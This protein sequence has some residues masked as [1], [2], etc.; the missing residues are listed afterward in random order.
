M[1]AIAVAG[2]L[3][4]VT[5]AVLFYVLVEPIDRSETFA[6]TAWYSVFQVAVLFGAFLYGVARR[7]QSG[8]TV[9]VVAATEMIVLAYNVV[10]VAVMIVFNVLLPEYRTVARYYVTNFAV[11]AVAAAS[12]ALLQLVPAAHNVGHAEAARARASVDDLVALCGAVGA[13]C[14]IEG[15]KREMTSVA[16]QIRFSE[17]LRVNPELAARV[18]D[19]IRLM[20]R[21]SVGALDEHAR[22]EG[23]RVLRSIKA[24]ASRRS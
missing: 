4:A 6:F 19:E 13:Q 11:T 9:P 10:T 17:G 8:V 21:L 16:E 7:R 15:W 20:D 12:L 24:L 14:E 23:D 5:V 22:H 18:A 3:L 2:A 1:L